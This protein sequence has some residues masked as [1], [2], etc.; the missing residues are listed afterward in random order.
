MD[1]IV[2]EVGWGL[3]LTASPASR[4]PVLGQAPYRSSPLEKEKAAND[5]EFLPSECT[6]QMENKHGPRGKPQQSL[7]LRCEMQ[8]REDLSGSRA[9]KVCGQWGRGSE[10]GRL[11]AGLVK[12]R[13]E[14]HSA[15]AAAQ[16]AETQQHQRHQHRQHG[17][18]R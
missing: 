8:V 2:E 15:A 16:E 9:S 4:Y 10:P 11:S 5:P 17:G 14:C 6:V 1:E 18:G 12:G 3:C 13:G 7:A